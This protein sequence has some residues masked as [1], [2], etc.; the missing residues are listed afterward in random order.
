MF[1]RAKGKIN[2]DQRSAGGFMGTGAG[3]KKTIRRSLWIKAC[4]CHWLGEYQIAEHLFSYM[5]TWEPVSERGVIWFQPEGF[6]VKGGCDEEGL[7]LFSQAT[8]RTQGHG[9][10]LYQRRFRLDIRRNFL[11]E[12][13]VRHWN[14]CSGR[15]WSR[16][17]WQCSRGVWMRS[18]EIWF[19]SLW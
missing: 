12:R 2:D 8:N 14:G 11:S 3:Y 5:Q 17:P 18:Y 1:G 6:I 19:S 7:G 16:R 9:H 13:V 10:K 15:W 4:K